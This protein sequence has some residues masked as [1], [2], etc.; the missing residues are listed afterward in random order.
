MVRMKYFTAPRKI[1]ILW[2]FYRWNVNWFLENYLESN[3]ICFILGVKPFICRVKVKI[4]FDVKLSGW[5]LKSQ[6]LKTA[7]IFR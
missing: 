2:F 4:I 3:Q 1:P 6:R 7:L 5:L